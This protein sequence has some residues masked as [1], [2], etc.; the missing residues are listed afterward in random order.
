VAPRDNPPGG[1]GRGWIVILPD[2]GGNAPPS[3]EDAGRADGSDRALL[4]RLKAEEART[5]ARAM[6]D[7]GA[8]RAMLQLAGTYDRLARHIAD[9]DVSQ[10]QRPPDRDTGQAPSND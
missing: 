5:A 4:F 3:P 10:D 6:T 2:D 1:D 8:R 9:R 7:A